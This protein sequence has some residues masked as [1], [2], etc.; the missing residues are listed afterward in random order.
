MKGMCDS[1]VLLLEH[2]FHDLINDENINHRLPF[3]FLMDHDVGQSV[4]VHY[5]RCTNNHYR[6]LTK[7]VASTFWGGGGSFLGILKW[8]V[9]FISPSHDNS[10]YM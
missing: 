10:E 3:N 1:R 4:S 8:K 9:S 7:D 2:L 6:H 5:H